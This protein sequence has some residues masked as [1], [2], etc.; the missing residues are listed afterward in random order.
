[1]KCYL[2][3]IFFVYSERKRERVKKKQTRAI[4]ETTHGQTETKSFLKLTKER[5]GKH[6]IEMIEQRIPNLKKK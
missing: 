6:L 3:P 2:P 4:C 5:N 1:M